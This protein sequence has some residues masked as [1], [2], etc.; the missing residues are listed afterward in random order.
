MN[1]IKEMNKRLDEREEEIER[2]NNIIKKIVSSCYNSNMTLGEFKE[3]WRIA[4]NEKYIIGNLERLQ[5]LKGS[6]SNE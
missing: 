2:L 6:E 1:S 4:F 5:E 3:I